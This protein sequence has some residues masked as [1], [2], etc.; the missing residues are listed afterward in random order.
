MPVLTGEE[1]MDRSKWMATELDA[2]HPVRSG[3]LGKHPG[4]FPL[5][6]LDA[7]DRCCDVKDIFWGWF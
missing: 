4:C 6:S 7:V 3:S 1:L 2:F 5:F